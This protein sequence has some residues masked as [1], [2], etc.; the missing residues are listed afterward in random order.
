MTEEERSTIPAW[1]GSTLKLTYHGERYDIGTLA[2]NDIVDEDGDGCSNAEE[3]SAAPELGGDRNPLDYFDFF[4]S[5]LD[6]A[7]D[8]TDALDVLASFGEGHVTN[9]IGIPIDR[10][11]KVG[12]GIFSIQTAYLDVEMDIGPGTICRT[13]A[14]GN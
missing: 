2:I 6:L 8:L 5:N 11:E 3:L 1:E 9:G 7:V 12:Y 14:T 4:D 10:R 13:K